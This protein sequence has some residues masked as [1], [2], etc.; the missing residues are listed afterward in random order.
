MN[1]AL[2]EPLDAEI[3][4]HNLGGLTESDIIAG[5]ASAR[6]FT[7]AGLDREAILSELSFNLDLSNPSAPLLRVNS[8]RPIREPYLDF[9]IDVRWPSG[10]L[11]REYT[12]L[13]DLP[14]YAA[15]RP[16]TSGVAAQPRQSREPTSSPAPLPMDRSYPA[17]STPLAGGSEYRVSAGETLWS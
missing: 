8:K 10:R 6:D 17:V 16:A 15:D 9:L 7:R 11:L 1:S 12:V 2:N 3:R 14:V 4:L 13:L 5:L